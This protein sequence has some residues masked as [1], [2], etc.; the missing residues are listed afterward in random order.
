MD[1]GR[2]GNVSPRGRTCE[3][4]RIG[5]RQCG[6]NAVQVRKP[7]LLL[8]IAQE[9]WASTRS[10]WPE[11]AVTNDSK[12][13][14]RRLRDLGVRLMMMTGDPLP[15]AGAVNS[16]V[17][18]GSRAGPTK[19]PG[20]GDRSRGAPERRFRWLFSRGQ[21]SHSP[22]SA[23]GRHGR[24]NDRRGGESES[25]WR[26]PQTWRKPRPVSRLPIPA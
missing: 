1:V 15:R 17:G 13:L 9:F 19:S 18:I 8:A 23:A 22:G 11:P 6:L 7:H 5:L 12:E 21:V 3:E 20:K 16:R 10:S 25:T 26:M 14:I 4:A 24:W 2:N